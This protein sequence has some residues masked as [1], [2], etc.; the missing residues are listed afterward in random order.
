MTAPVGHAQNRTIARVQII[1]GRL[2]QQFRAVDTHKRHPGWTRRGFVMHRFSQ[3][4]A[5][6]H[7]SGGHLSV[8]RP[9]SDLQSFEIT[10]LVAI[11]GR[12]REVE[13]DSLK[14]PTPDTCFAIPLGG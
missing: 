3:E 5:S 2:A 7:H 4:V 1:A 11:L 6:I 10:A 8:C 14:S 9:E 12:L 13:S